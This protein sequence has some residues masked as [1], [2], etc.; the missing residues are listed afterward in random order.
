M[1]YDV[2]LG[3]L[4]ISDWYHYDPFSMFHF[5]ITVHAPLPV[6][7]IVNGKGHYDCDPEQDTFCTGK[8]KELHEVS[9]QQGTTYKIGLVN[10]GSLTTYKFW[11]DGHNFTVVAAD[12]VPIKPFATDVLILGIGRLFLMVTFPMCIQRPFR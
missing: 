2:D 12:F 5:E 9:F 8:K 6:G 4:L 11:I 3:P 1:N 10:T 7:T